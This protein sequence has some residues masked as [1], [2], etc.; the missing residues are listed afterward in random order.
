M[1]YYKPPHHSSRLFLYFHL[2]PENSV[3]FV[4]NNI[5]VCATYN[6]VAIGTSTEII[7]ADVIRE[8]LLLLFA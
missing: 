5:Y 4:T 8:V 7:N 2:I 6:C 3:W 1:K